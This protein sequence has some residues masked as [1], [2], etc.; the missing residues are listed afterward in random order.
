MIKWLEENKKFSVIFLAI[1][2]VEIFLVSSLHGGKPT[3]GGINLSV[4]YHII[5]FLLFNFFLLI[6]LNK[7]Q[8]LTGKYLVVVLI[9]SVAY[10]IL[11]EL[12]QIFVPLRDASIKDVLIDSTGIFLS[13]LVYIYYK[14]KIRDIF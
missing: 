11:D 6:S 12:H 7:D 1:I 4:A 3:T 9:L 13:T 5:I 10:A 14:R 2:A 8:E